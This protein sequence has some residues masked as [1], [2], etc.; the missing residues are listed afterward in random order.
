L[1]WQ[2]ASASSRRAVSRFEMVLEM[3]VFRG[4]PV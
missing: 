2:P 3:F 1:A 4:L